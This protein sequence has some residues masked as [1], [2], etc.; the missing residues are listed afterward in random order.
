MCATSPDPTKARAQT[1][2]GFNSAG[3]PSVIES[4]RLLDERGQLII[5]HRGKRYQLR[6]TR[7]GKL[8]LTS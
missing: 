5:E 8:I 2:E 7:N 4:S 6:E 3:R 1:T